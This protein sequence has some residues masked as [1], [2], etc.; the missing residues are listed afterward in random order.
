MRKKTFNPPI[1]V[2]AILG[3]LLL[4]GYV[5]GLF[6]HVGGDAIHF[7]LVIALVMITLQLFM[8]SGSRI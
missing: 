5:A 4:V 3:I 2:F 6:L 8:R 1:L 7:A